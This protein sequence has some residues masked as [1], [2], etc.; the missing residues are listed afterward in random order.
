MKTSL[1]GDFDGFYNIVN[2]LMMKQR[3]N[4]GRSNYISGTAA[5]QADNRRSGCQCFDADNTEILLGR[6]NK[7]A[8]SCDSFLV[9]GIASI[10]EAVGAEFDG[11]A[12]KLD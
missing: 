8:R 6:I 3:A 12:G 9:F 10:A 2:S 4:I 7:A 1:F 5:R 11:W